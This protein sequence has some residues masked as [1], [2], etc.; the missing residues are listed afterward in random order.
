MDEQFDPVQI[1]IK[2]VLDV[3]KARRQGMDM[4]LVMGFPLPEATKI[5]VVISELA[6][7]IL[8]HAG[9][10]GSITLITETG[11]RKGIRVIARDQGPGIKDI[12]IALKGGFSTARGLGLGLSGS[13]NLMDEFEVSSTVGVGTVVTA[14]KWISK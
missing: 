14:V 8:I 6:R 3:V 5:A 12:G 7:N 2:L 1:P 10:K 13:R 9:G 11:A 4:A